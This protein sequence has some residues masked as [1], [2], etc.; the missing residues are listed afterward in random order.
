VSTKE[1]K[2][3]KGWLIIAAGVGLISLTNG[4]EVKESI[5][6]QGESKSERTELRRTQRRSTLAIDRAK[7]GCINVVMDAYQV[8]LASTPTRLF[9]GQ[10]A[11]DQYGHAMSDGSFIC[12]PLGDTAV[13]EGGLVSD[14]IRV[15]PEDM[16][17]FKLLIG[18]FDQL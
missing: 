5:S 18:A 11:V 14:V 1:L 13:V 8:G 15:A 7:A 10:N 2:E 12:S 6:H 9:E 4:G 16:E 3:M 17:E